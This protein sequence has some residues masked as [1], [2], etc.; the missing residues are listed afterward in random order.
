MAKSLHTKFQTKHNSLYMPKCSPRP[1]KKKI[2][3]VASRCDDFDD[4][5]EYAKSRVQET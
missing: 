4:G 2:P 3:K 1:T 5:P